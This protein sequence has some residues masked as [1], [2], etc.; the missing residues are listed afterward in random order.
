MSMGG[1]GAWELAMAQP[2]RFAAIAPICGRPSLER[3]D[4]LA[5][6]PIWTFHGAKD[7]VVP[8]AGT[9]AMVDA[10]RRLG[11]SVRYTCYPDAGHDSWTETYANKELYTW[12][13]SH[14]RRRA[15]DTA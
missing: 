9:E 6:L 2:G 15:G 3:A 7:P 1:S 10:L 4:L 14:T 5:R 11:S 8:I 12:L 13:L